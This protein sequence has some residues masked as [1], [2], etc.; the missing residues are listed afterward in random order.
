MKYLELMELSWF[1]PSEIFGRFATPPHGGGT[2]SSWRVGEPHSSVGQSPTSKDDD[3][4]TTHPGV[5][6][7]VWKRCPDFQMSLR[8]VT[9][10][11]SA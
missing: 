3:S 5:Y 8:N 2:F 11:V 7:T 6:S 1:V 9:H 4:V 10:A